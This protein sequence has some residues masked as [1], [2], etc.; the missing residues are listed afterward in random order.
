MPLRAPGHGVQ[1]S[2]TSIPSDNCVING[3]DFPLGLMLAPGE[4]VTAEYVIEGSSDS[5]AEA[6]VRMTPGPEDGR[7]SASTSKCTS[8]A[9]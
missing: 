1:Q 6:K 4:S 8:K 3:F 9:S 7:F 5:L 2:V